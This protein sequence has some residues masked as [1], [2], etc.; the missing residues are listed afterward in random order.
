[1]VRNLQEVA[2]K[3]FTHFYIEILM[4]L[5]ASGGCCESVI[6]GLESPGGC[7]EAI[8]TFLQRN[9][10]GFKFIGGCREAICALFL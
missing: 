10:D 9:I 5:E 7:C 6:D 3:P 4:V 1:M 8:Y 2:V